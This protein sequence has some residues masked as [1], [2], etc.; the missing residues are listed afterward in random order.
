MKFGNASMQSLAVAS[1]ALQGALA[2]NPKNETE[3]LNNIKSLNAS[4]IVEKAQSANIDM[5]SAERL[6]TSISADDVAKWQKVFTCEFDTDCGDNGKC[7]EGPTSPA[8]PNGTLSCEC[9]DGFVNNPKTTG[10]TAKPGEV[11][12]YKQL[13]QLTQTLLSWFVGWTGADWFNAA[14][15]NPNYLAAGSMK[16]LAT[17]AGAAAGALV[18]SLCGGRGAIGGAGVGAGAGG[19]AQIVWSLVDAIRITASTTS[20][21]DGNGVPLKPF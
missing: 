11:C 4:N 21:P 17:P 7:V 13:P 19:A 2:G 15:A 10:N 14:K 5:R 12:N 16:L 3:L 9:D 18:G 6:L 20:M 1:L 8:F